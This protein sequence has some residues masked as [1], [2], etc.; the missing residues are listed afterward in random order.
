MGADPRFFK[1]LDP[2][3]AAKLC[4]QVNGRLFGHADIVIHMIASPGQA[5]PGDLFFLTNADHDL[6]ELP[7][8]TIGLVKTDEQARAVESMG[9]T[10]IQVAQPKAS[11]ARI[12]RLLVEPIIHEGNDYIHD[13]ASVHDSVRMGP[14]V[15]IGPGAVI[16]E[17]V[18]LSPGVVIGPGV[19]IGPGTRIGP[20]AS[21]GFSIIGARCDIGAGAVLGETGFGLAQEDGELFTLPHVGRVII[22]DECTLGANVTIDRGM[23]DDTKLG[24]GCR[25]DNLSHIAHNVKVGE[26]TVMA[27]FAGIS[28]STVIGKGVQF[29]G[30]VGIADHLNIGDRAA[31]AADSA[32]MKNVPS[33]EVWAG[34]PAQPRQKW[35]REIAW[36][37]KQ[38]GLRKRKT[39]T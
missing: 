16:S 24:R 10:A 19:S 38:A 25:I 33:G 6:S 7:K 29:G 37:R 31:L 3:K 4:E 27:A 18:I 8:G 22:E 20:R 15:V 13:T 30:R 5:R 34:S 11:L 21:I 14:G 12:A 39:K 32:V 26:Q 35:F 1:A 9:L 17:D 28:G 36:V 23:F 2:I